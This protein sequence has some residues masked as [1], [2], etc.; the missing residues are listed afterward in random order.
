[1]GKKLI[2]GCGYL[3]QRIA[4]L[5]LAQKH[6]VFATTRSQTRAIE[7]ALNPFCAM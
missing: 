6:R 3:G 2:I 7:L 1:M 5:W 4:T